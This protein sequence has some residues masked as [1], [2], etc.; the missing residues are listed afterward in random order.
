MELGLQFGW[1]MMEH[2][3]S[4]VRSWG[5]GTVILSPRDLKPEQLESLAGDIAGLTGGRVLLDPQFYV[6]RSDHERLTSHS[7]WPDTY[8]T[9]TFFGGPGMDAMLRDVLALNQRLGAD[10]FIVPGPLGA[11]VD[12]TWLG[13]VSELGR[14]ATD[15]G[16]EI[17]LYLT[18]ALGW[19]PLR[20]LD[21]VQEVLEEL[22]ELDV[23]GV[24]LLAEPP[25]GSY[26]VDD[27]VWMANLAELVAGLR[28]QQKKV[29]LGYAN[30]QMLFLAAAGLRMIASGTWMNVRSF[31]PDRFMALQEDEVRRKTTWYYAPSA[32]SEFKIP[33]L[34]MA[35]RGGLLQQLESPARFGSTYASQLFQGVQP[36]SVGFG[37]Q[38]AFRHY[39]HCLR[40]QATESRQATFDDTVAHHRQALDDAEAQL[41]VL[42]QSGV[43]PGQRGFGD[44][45]DAI[46]AALASLVG[47]RGPALR[48]YWGSL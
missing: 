24:Y 28:L 39:L 14:A 33:S 23:H 2:S 41:D 6:P 35:D 36:S 13:I 30:H 16:A 10:A 5:G 47:T 26:L 11:T 21:S 4:L 44:T 40:H 8:Q 46:R 15:L 3:R 29:L 9:N 31:S 42:G 32:L 43:L 45:L 20:S 12:D 37:E 34:D 1:G 25:S 22:R 18:I 17:P 48:R 19:E 7:Y 38:D 27:P